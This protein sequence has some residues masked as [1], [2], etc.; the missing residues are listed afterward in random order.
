MRRKPDD[1]D[2]PRLTTTG[3]AR[4]RGCSES[5]VRAANNRGEL[6]AERTESGLRLF[7]RS[8]VL[9]WLERRGQ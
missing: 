9:E 5:A 4:L 1:D 2:E 7:R 6:P 8:D 3:V